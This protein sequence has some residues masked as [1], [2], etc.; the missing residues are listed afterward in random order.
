MIIREWRARAPLSLAHAYPQHFHARVLPEL[1]H[2][3]GFRGAWLTQ[4]RVGESMEFLVLTRWDSME[5][6]RGF[7][8]ADAEKAVVEPAAQ[9]VLSS[10]DS[11]VRH[12]EVLQETPL[13]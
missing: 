4:R 2:V 13:A 3:P 11:H 5:A 7:A 8:G 9:A 12:Y 6:I 10:F 1:S